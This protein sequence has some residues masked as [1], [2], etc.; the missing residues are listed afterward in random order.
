[1]IGRTMPPRPM[2]DDD[3]IVRLRIAPD[4]LDRLLTDGH[5][6]GIDRDTHSPVGLGLAENPDGSMSLVLVSPLAYRA[7]HAILLTEVD[8]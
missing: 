7:P 5:V 4:N 1:M 6:L 8:R 3:E 2:R